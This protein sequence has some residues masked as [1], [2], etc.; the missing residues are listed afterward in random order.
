VV[1]ATRAIGHTAIQFFIYQR[2]SEEVK[3]EMRAI[4]IE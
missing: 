1:L 2:S 4:K 3:T